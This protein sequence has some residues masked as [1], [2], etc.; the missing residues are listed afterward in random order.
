MSL[1]ISWTTHPTKSGPIVHLIM[2]EANIITWWGHST[3]GSP[4]GE[5][6]IYSLHLPFISDTPGWWQAASRPSADGVTWE[7][8]NWKLGVKGPQTSAATWKWWMQSHTLVGITIKSVTV[9]TVQN[10]TK[11]IHVLFPQTHMNTVHVSI[12][13]NN[14]E[15]LLVTSCHY[16]KGL[17]NLHYTTDF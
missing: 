16:S 8:R 12:A 2:H 17:S 4:A 6:H 13:Y 3:K 7:G 1:T 14:K 9:I 15:K 10:E 5:K 11:Y